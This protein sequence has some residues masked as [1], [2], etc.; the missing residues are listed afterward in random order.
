MTRVTQRP[1]HLRRYKRFLWTQRGSGE[2]LG[3]STWRS[4]Q[5]AGVEARAQQWENG[6]NVWLMDA[7][8]K[9]QDNVASGPRTRGRADVGPTLLTLTPCG[10]EDGCGDRTLLSAFGPSCPP[11]EVRRRRTADPAEKPCALTL[12]SAPKHAAALA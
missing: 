7:P 3:V 11:R 8:E 4:D 9:L 12:P 5:T 1:A 6:G 10:R 2:G